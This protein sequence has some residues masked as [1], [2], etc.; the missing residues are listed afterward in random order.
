MS[1]D[2][3]VA[4]SLPAYAL[5]ILDEE[6]LAHVAQHLARCGN[7]RD[8]LQS[9]EMI[10]DRLALAAPDHEPPAR[11][12]KRLMERVSL[13][14]PEEARTWLQQL[15]SLFRQAMPVWGLAIVVLIVGL[16][17]SNLWLWQQVKQS[18][19]A[20]LPQG[21]QVVVLTGTEVAPSAT[22]ALVVSEG[23]E[24]GTLVVDDLPPL[25]AEH[26][27]QLWLIRDGARTSG[28]VFSVNDEGYGALWVSAPEPLISYP[29]FGITVEPA[30]GSPG[31]TGDKVM[32][33]DL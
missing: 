28:G 30:G 23:G 13:P 2:R 26:E 4:E 15:A 32:G 33:G 1:V 22:G 7:C 6:E 17:L 24:Y 9:Y 18:K 21:M 5:G 11:L 12:K 10:A 29:A 20:T 16:A 14:A 8:E 25:D 3:H 27:Y 19:Q 31:P